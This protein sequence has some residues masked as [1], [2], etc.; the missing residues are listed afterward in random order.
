MRCRLRPCRQQHREVSEQRQVAATG[1]SVHPRYTWSLFLVFLPCI[2]VGLFA[3]SASRWAGTPE[4]KLSPIPGC[5]VDP[6]ALSVLLP[7]SL[8]LP[9]RC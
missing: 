1:T 7:R 4:A 2:R 3:E 5:G 9:S 6:V 8:S